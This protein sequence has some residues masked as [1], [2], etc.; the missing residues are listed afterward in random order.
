MTHK[1]EIVAPW[2]A[3]RVHFDLLY[4][5]LVLGNLDLLFD[6]CHFI[7]VFH[8]SLVKLL[9]QLIRIFLHKIICLN[10]NLII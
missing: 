6:L 5:V 1:V 8:L 9:I 4:Y 2:L 7:K 3:I 10:I